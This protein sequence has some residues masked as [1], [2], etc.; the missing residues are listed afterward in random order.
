LVFLQMLQTHSNAAFYRIARPG[1]MGP[2]I[3]LE[4]GADLTILRPAFPEGREMTVSTIQEAIEDIRAGKMVILVDDEDRENEGDLVIAAQF[5]DASAINFMARNGRGLICLTLTAAQ[6]EK[7]GLSLMTTKNES[8]F[9]TAFTVSIEA[10]EGVTTGISAAD[11]ARTI[12][13]AIRPDATGRDIV[14]PGHV[15]PIRAREGGVLVRSGQTEGSVD[16][17]RLAGLNP[18][19]VICEVMN[20]DGTMAR[21]PQLLEFGEKHGIRVVTVADLIRY[22][23]ERE[24]F[25][26][27]LADAK[28]PRDHSDWHIAL[29]EN[30]IDGS[31]HPAFVLGEISGD[32]PVLVRVHSECLTGDV[33]G[34]TRCDC[35]PQLHKSIEMIE[36]EGAGVLLYLR[37]EGRGIGLP[38]KIKAYHLQDDGKDTVEANLALGLKPDLRDYGIGAQMLKDLG[39]RRIRL[40]TNNPRKIIGI[41]GFGLEVVERVPIEI[42]PLEENIDYLR[43]KKRKMG[44]LL[45][46][47]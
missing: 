9:N 36:A 37:Q 24:S 42:E 28:V 27:R 34:S 16:L 26:R 21:L 2:V 14:S 45:S 8:P 23:L 31:H 47:V 6:V 32:K 22:R 35:G 4:S 20:E 1:T 39:V 30:M 46:K 44:H 13:T 7:L 10:R 5:V 38:A 40:L 18:S 15:F 17:A 12:Q 29:Y 43:T 11:R 41:G 25:V 19:G 33:F 3:Q